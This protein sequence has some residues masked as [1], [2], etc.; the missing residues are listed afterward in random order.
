MPSAL[1]IPAAL[2]QTHMPNF[3][4]MPPGESWPIA[5]QLVLLPSCADDVTA[6]TPAQEVHDFSKQTC[7]VRKRTTQKK[8]KGA[9]MA[10]MLSGLPLMRCKAR[11]EGWWLRGVLLL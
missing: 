10:Y 9:Q 8:D 5:V 6:D 11:Q 4:A 7:G 2:V 3:A 1:R